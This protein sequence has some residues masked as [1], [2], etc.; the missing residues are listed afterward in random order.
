MVGTWAY[1]N[2]M[3]NALTDFEDYKAAQVENAQVLDAMGKKMDSMTAEE[4]GDF[5]G[6]VAFEVVLEVATVGGAAALTTLK[7]ADK[8]LDV[9]KAVDKMDDLNDLGK[10][11]EKIQ[12][13]SEIVIHDGLNEFAP[14]KLGDVVNDAGIPERPSWKDSEIDALDDYPSY[15][16]QKS[17]L[18]GKEVPYGKKGSTRPDLY[19]KGHSIEVKNYDVTTSRGRSRLKSEL[20]RQYNSRVENLPKGTK[21]SAIIDVRGQNI[22]PKEL[23]KLKESINKDAKNLEIIFKN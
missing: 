2:S 16:E 17:F 3:V 12:D 9:V 13:G 10:A 1:R 6:Q 7:A 5:T 21:Q 11:G 18:D 8:G 4:W 20:K 19:S 15:E 14:Q 22:S 23:K